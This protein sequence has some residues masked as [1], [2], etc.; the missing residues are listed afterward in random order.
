MSSRGIWKFLEKNEQME[1]KSR[2][3]VN[4]FNL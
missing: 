1:K 2:V 4:I 3:L